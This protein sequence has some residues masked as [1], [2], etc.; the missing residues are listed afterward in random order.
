MLMI[1]V[2]ILAT[3]FGSGHFAAQIRGKPWAFQPKSL[4]CGGTL[5]ATI[6]PVKAVGI[7]GKGP[8]NPGQSPQIIRTFGTPQGTYEKGWLPSR[9]LLAGLAVTL[10]N[11]WLG[12][13]IM[14]RNSANE[15]EYRAQL[16]RLIYEFGACGAF[17]IV[18]IA[19]CSFLTTP[20]DS[21]ISW[22]YP[23]FM[24][25]ITVAVWIVGCAGFYAVAKR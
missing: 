12:T 14:K 7:V 25:T 16:R 18:V 9:Q 3:V 1:A 13:R 19:T 22:G 17:A 4:E 8:E 6:W 15:A 5:G 24:G 20:S 10:A 11:F 21:P 23:A 2:A